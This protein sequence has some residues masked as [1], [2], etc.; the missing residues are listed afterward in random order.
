LVAE[1]VRV[2]AV[3]VADLE[4]NLNGQV[5]DYFWRCD[6]PYLLSNAKAACLA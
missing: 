4:I 2:I 6:P 3:T 5:G 1:S